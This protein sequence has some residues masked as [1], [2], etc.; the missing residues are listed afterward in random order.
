MGSLQSA[1][2]GNASNKSTLLKSH[3]SLRTLLCHQPDPVEYFFLLSLT[4]FSSLA[5][6]RYPSSSPYITTPLGHCSSLLITLPAPSC[7]LPLIPSAHPAQGLISPHIIIFNMLSL[8]SEIS[9]CS[10]WPSERRLEIHSLL[11]KVLQVPAD[12]T[13]VLSLCC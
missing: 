7:S 11:V 6:C 9:D 8:Y 5:L 13:E 3:P 2:F 12:L 4:P 10:L 1:H